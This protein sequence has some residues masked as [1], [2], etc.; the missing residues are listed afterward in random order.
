MAKYR[1]WA[2]LIGTQM[3]PDFL[4]MVFNVAK[5]NIRVRMAIINEDAWPLPSVTKKL[6]ADPSQR[7]GF[8]KF[9]ADGREVFTD[10]I[11]KAYEE[12]N[13]LYGTDVQPPDYR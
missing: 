9:I 2:F 13:K 11:K 8:T 6:P 3:L 7:I 4:L 1:P 12:T 5:D 10:V